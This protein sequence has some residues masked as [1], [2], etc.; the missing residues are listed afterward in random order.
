MYESLKNLILHRAYAT[1]EDAERRVNKAYPK[2]ITE[3]QQGELLEL[4]ADTY[5]REYVFGSLEVHV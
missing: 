5:D 1:R 2:W 3:T 4:V